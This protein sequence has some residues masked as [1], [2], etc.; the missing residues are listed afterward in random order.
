MMTPAT[1]R[2]RNPSTKAPASPLPRRRMKNSAQALGCRMCERPMTPDR[3]TARTS[4]DLSIRSPGAS[5]SCLLR[6][7][8]TCACAPPCLPSGRTATNEPRDLGGSIVTAGGLVFIGAT[9][10][11]QVRAFDSATGHLLW[12]HKLPFGGYA[13]P[14]TYAVNG[15]QFLVIAAGGGGKLGTESGDA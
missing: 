2:F 11:E 3:I 7:S 1:G 15:R 9:M 13:T 12:Q 4:T 8:P 10:D 14:S 6:P 5:R